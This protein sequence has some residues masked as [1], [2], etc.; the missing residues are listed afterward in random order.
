MLGDA[1]SRVQGVSTLDGNR[2]FDWLVSNDGKWTP[3]RPIPSHTEKVTHSLG[4]S[5]VGKGHGLRP[6]AKPKRYKDLLLV[7]PLQS[8]KCSPDTL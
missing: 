1:A 8:L 4:L 5:L 7:R 6:N 3:Q 2:M